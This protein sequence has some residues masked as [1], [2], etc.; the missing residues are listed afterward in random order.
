MSRFTLIPISVLAIFAIN[1]IASTTASAHAWL[2][3]GAP[4]TQTEHTLSEGGLFIEAAWTQVIDCETVRSLA[5]LLVGG[6]GFINSIHFLN[7]RTAQ[8]GCDVHSPGAPD[9]LILVLNIPTLIV[10]RE[11]AQGKKVLADEFKTNPT[12]KEFSKLEFLTLSGGSC[13]EY[14]LLSSTK[15]QFA[16]EISGGLLVFPNPELKGNTFEAFGIVAKYIG[17]YTQM[18]TNGGVLSAE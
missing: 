13:S 3:N 1:T 18:F 14:G 12:T 11:N 10:E 2:K 16:V 15:G 17:D 7:C 5:L 9:G 4:I 6:R 8:A